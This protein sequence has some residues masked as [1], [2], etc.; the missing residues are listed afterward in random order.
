M[1]AADRPAYAF[2]LRPRGRVAGSR[3]PLPAAREAFLAIG[4]TPLAERARREL[5]A[6]GENTPRHLPRASD[7]LT[8]QELQIAQMAA[9]GMSNRE[10]GQSLFLSHPTVGSHLYQLF[11]NLS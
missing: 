8:P 2:W 6:S 7:R 5:R 1:F 10:I 3:A 4:A 9:A 11:P